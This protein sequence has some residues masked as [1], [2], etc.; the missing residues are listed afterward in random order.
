VNHLVNEK[1]IQSNFDVSAPN[2]C[3]A[4]FA[5][6]FQA[7]EHCSHDQRAQILNALEPR[8]GSVHDDL[9]GKLGLLL[10]SS[11]MSEKDRIQ[12]LWLLYLS[13][14]AYPRGDVQMWIGP[15]LFSSDSGEYLRLQLPEA[16]LS[17]LQKLQE[18]MRILAQVVRS[19]VEVEIS[20]SSSGH[21]V[22]DLR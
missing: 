7:L 19:T 15:D 12:G 9:H 11:G 8:L 16:M 4:L 18:D 14:V 20:R 6:L 1:A 2:A 5:A 10:N 21:L 17:S 3:A 22:V 13:F